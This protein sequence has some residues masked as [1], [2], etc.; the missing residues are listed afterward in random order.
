MSF[1][2]SG[3]TSTL[4]GAGGAGGGFGHEMLKFSAFKGMSVMSGHVVALI[5]H[6]GVEAN[7]EPALW[8]LVPYVHDQFEC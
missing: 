2:L 4:G 3:H 8:E 6:A 5:A 7:S 1:S